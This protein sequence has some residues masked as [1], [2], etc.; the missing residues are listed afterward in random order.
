MS[1]ADSSTEGAGQAYNVR[2]VKAE[3]FLRSCVR[4]WL[5]E[6]GTVSPDG[7]PWEGAHAWNLYSHG[8]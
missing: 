5:E 8:Q 2:V 4:T 6:Q 7:N 1:S 3:E